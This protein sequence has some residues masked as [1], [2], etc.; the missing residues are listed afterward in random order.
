MSLRMILITRP[1]EQAKTLEKK[2]RVLNIKYFTESLSVIKFKNKNFKKYHN[3]TYL[4]SSPRVIDLLIQQK[5]EYHKLKFFIIGTSSG[6]RLSQAGF[7]NILGVSTNRIKMLSILKKQKK[8]SEIEYLTGTTI[9]KAFYN[10]IKKLNINLNVRILYETCYIES[11][12]SKCESLIFNKEIKIVLLYSNANAAHFIN[13]LKKANLDQL[14]SEIKFLCLSKKI[15]Q[16]VSNSGFNSNYTK[17][18]NER[19]M[20][21]SIIR[22]LKNVKS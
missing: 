11:L 22:N 9:N 4:V 17:L 5:S 1:K 2:L 15:A 18:P 21:L 8:I 16:L 13:L 19:S 3:K 10:N 14:S 12:S 7:E 6:E 20:I